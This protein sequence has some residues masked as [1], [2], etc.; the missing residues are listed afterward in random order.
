VPVTERIRFYFDPT[1]PWAWQS[2]RWMR[3]VE[4]VRDVRADWRLFSLRLVNE[5]A[6]DPLTDASAHSVPALRALALAGRECGN[7]A[8]ADLY[9]A[10]GERIHDRDEELSV[11]LIRE[12]LT[13]AGLDP[14]TVDRALADP[15]TAEDVRGQHREAVESVQAFGVPTI[16]L[17]S[18]R[19]IFGPV[20]A[21]APAGEEA[22]RVWD[23]VR[24]LA[25]FDGFFELKRERDRRAGE[26]AAVG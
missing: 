20:V 17:E 11:E 25:D 5:S 24:W 10:I 6:D 22:G 12:A 13:A 18:G 16:I 14:A 23:H 15:T 19:G 4:R 1:C 3:E 7:E 21:L 8:V 2:A 9:W 26:G